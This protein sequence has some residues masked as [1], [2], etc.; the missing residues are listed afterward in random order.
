MHRLGLASGY[1]KIA[2]VQSGDE[3]SEHLTGPQEH[4]PCPYCYATS[5]TI[6]EF[7]DGKKCIRCG[8]CGAMSP[9]AATEALARKKYNNRPTEY[10]AQKLCEIYFNIAAEAIGEDAVRA[11]RD[12]ALKGGE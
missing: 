11:K 5:F 9:L 1:V 2:N 3:M 4:K 12:A 7:S 10:A 8:S 6:P